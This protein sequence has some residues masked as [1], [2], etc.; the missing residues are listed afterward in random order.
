M[1]NGIR[2]G[3]STNKKTNINNVDLSVHL[4][5][6]VKYSSIEKV[7]KTPLNADIGA[8]L[9]SNTDQKTIEKRRLKA[10]QAI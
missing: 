8:H 2:R 7:D 9:N 3:F 10:E 5:K 6:R 4:K 1:L